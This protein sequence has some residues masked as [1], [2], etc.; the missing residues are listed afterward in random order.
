[1]R[2]E[3]WHMTDK[4]YVVNQENE[5]LTEIANEM[6]DQFSVDAIKGKK[7][8]K[9]E[10]KNSNI[11]LESEKSRE[12]SEALI[13]QVSEHLNNM[14]KVAKNFSLVK[15]QIDLNKKISEK[16][17]D[18]KRGKLNKREYNKMKSMLDL[19]FEDEKSKFDFFRTEEACIQTDDLEARDR[20]SV[21]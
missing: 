20:K 8:I 13:Q 10:R 15:L 5:K 17:E 9:K 21:V 1:M 3:M 19:S 7:M 2:N 6:I 4:M 16:E 14:N 12:E 18:D 11:K